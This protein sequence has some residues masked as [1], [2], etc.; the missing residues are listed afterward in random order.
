MTLL[1][2]RSKALDNPSCLMVEP[3]EIH[4]NAPVIT[5]K[6]KRVMTQT[7]QIIPGSLLK[8][9]KPHRAYH[10]DTLFVC[11]SIDSES[12]VASSHFD[13]PTQGPNLIWNTGG[14]WFE[15]VGQAITQ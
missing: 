10:S 5:F 6:G 15:V 12:L 3:C 4:H 14:D 11:R 7:D 13:E 8:L 1:S 2:M 9:K